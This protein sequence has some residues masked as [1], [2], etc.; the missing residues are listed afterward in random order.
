[1]MTCGNAACC[2]RLYKV[3]TSSNKADFATITQVNDT[4]VE[5][6]SLHGSACMLDLS[7]MEQ[8]A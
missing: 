2:I 1:M 6:P 8:E 7:A 5:E 4:Y 3:S